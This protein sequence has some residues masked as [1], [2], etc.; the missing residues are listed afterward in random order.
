MIDK[1][2]KRPV[3]VEAVRIVDIENDLSDLWP[4]C[5][6]TTV[7]SEPVVW[8][9][10]HNTWVKFKNGDWIVRGI[11]GE[12]YPVVHD[13]FIRTYQRSAYLSDRSVLDEA[14]TEMG[15]Q[16]AKWGEQNHPAK[17]GNAADYLTNDSNYFR[18]TTD[19][20]ADAGI[21]TWADILLEEVAEALDAD[22]LADVREELVQ[23]MAVT[24]S[25][26]ESIDRNGR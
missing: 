5:D 3:E 4:D 14:K 19:K 8:D 24:A 11:S 20:A 21:L 12:Y 6:I 26:I 1:W 7:D 10:L 13:V 18:N 16:I 17:D 2:T 25:C 9:K 23:V 22:D 15:R